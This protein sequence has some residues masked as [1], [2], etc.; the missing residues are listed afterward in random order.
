MLKYVVIKFEMSHGHR[1]LKICQA[2]LHGGSDAAGFRLWSSVSYE[3]VGRL[4]VLHAASHLIKL[5]N[6]ISRSPLEVLPP[7]HLHG[8][9]ALCISLV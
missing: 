5:L 2:G 7:P 8:V 3:P 9:G 6:Y 4:Y 1:C